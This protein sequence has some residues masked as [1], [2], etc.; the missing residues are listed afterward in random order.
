[1]NDE[2]VLRKVKDLLSESGVG[3][4]ITLSDKG[5][6]CSR[7][8]TPVFLP[9]LPGALYAV[10]SKESRKV[11]QLETNPNV[12]WSFQSASLDKIATLTGTA[13]IVKD[14]SLAAEVLEAIG[15]HLEVFWTY[16]GDP[17]KL[18]VIETIIESASWFKPLGGGN[19]KEEASY[20]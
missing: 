1:M 12:S 10:T 19:F 7:W 18:V 3:I 8:L 17:K 11:R 16:M 13:E 6:P 5:K 9:R 4:F 20:E 2:S 15:P 14:P